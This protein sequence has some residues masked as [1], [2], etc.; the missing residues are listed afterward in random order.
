[1]VE[2]GGKEHVVKVIDGGAKFDVGQGGRKLLKIKIAAEIDGV[3]SEYTITFTRRGPG[4][5]AKGYTYARADPD[6]REA[7]AERFSALVKALTGKEPWI[8]RMKDGRIKIGCGRG[9]LDGFRRYAELAD[10]IEKWLEQ[11]D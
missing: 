1:V 10:A 2:V 4:S 11:S 8:Q 3:E 9:H 5:G 7:D 6:G